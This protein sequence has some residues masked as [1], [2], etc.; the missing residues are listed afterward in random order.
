VLV[1]L[2]KGG[3][4]E[5][6]RGPRGFPGV[7]AWVVGQVLPMFGAK[8]WCHEGSEVVVQGLQDTWARSMGEPSE[9]VPD[10]GK[11]RVGLLTLVFEDGPVGS[12]GAG[13][14]E[15]LKLLSVGVGCFF[16]GTPAEFSKGGFGGLKLGFDLLCPLSLRSRGGRGV[17]VEHGEGSEGGRVG[18]DLVSGVRGGTS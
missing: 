16:F 14:E 18:G 5:G 9:G 7:V 17:Q 10:G 4:G 11:G 12:A 3:E 15:M 13:G 6:V 8:G 1:G 2:G